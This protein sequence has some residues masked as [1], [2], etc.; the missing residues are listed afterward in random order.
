M[1]DLGAV[2]TI[3]APVRVPAMHHQLERE[4]GFVFVG[5]CDRLHSLGERHEDFVFVQDRHELTALGFE[6][7][8]SIGEERTF[9]GVPKGIKRLLGGWVLRTAPIE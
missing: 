8:T 3:R 1:V 4:R 9:E 5:C 7:V 2:P 6:E